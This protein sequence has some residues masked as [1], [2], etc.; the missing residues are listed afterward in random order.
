MSVRVVAA[1]L[2]EYEA[3]LELRAEMSRDSHEPAPWDEIKPGWREGFREFFTGRQAM[4]RAQL[5]LAYDGAEAIGMCITYIA[6]HYRTAVLGRTYAML[7]G[8]FVKPAYRR[9]G[10]ARALT[11]AAIDW[12]RER[13]CYSVRLHSSDMA[14]PLYGSLGF[15]PTS[16]ME[17][18]LR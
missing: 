15:E 8:V 14:R 7:H 3:G 12:A 6:E 2:D 13:R 17:L 5:F 1:G 18:R 9:R 16:E 11:G 10:I 4:G